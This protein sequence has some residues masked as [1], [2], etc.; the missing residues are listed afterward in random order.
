[1]SPSNDSGFKVEPFNGSNNTLW[2]FKMKML[3]VTKKLW[4]A[5]ISINYCE[6]AASAR[7]D[8]FEPGGL[9][10]DARY[11]LEYCEGCVGE[12]G[13]VSPHLR[14]GESSGARNKFSS[15]KYT[16]SS[17]SSHFTELEELVLKMQSA[18]CGSSEEDICA[19]MLR[20]L[21]PSYE[22]LL[23]EFRMAV[24]SFRFSDL[25]S[26]LI[27]EEVRQS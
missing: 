8:S 6:G 12:A 13:N 21:P 7:G 10:A 9:A 19:V 15:F 1:M 24:T 2:S 3:L 4:N 26:K 27:A 16:A 5:V 22:G 11:R 23:Q 20:S 14:H 17:I 25:V 18:S